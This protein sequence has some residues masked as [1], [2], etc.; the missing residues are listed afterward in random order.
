VG[1]QTTPADSTRA[2]SLAQD[3]H[4]DPGCQTGSYDPNAEEGLMRPCL[5]HA[6]D[7]EGPG[8]AG[9]FESTEG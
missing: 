3:A 9:G 2:H 7:R 1:G 6:T 5:G 8:Y 4:Q